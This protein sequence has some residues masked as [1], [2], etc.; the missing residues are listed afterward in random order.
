MK[1]NQ[2]NIFFIK[3]HGM[4]IRYTFL[5]GATLAGI[6]VGSVLAILVIVVVVLVVLV[7]RR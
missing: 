5:V 4:Q 2:R 3:R 1:Y 7:L 6:V